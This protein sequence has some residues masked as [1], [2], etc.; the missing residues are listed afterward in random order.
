LY[1]LHQSGIIQAADLASEGGAH[2]PHLTYESHFLAEFLL[3][4]SPADRGAIGSYC[5][6]EY[7]RGTLSARQTNMMSKDHAKICLAAGAKM[8]ESRVEL[9]IE[10]MGHI[11][12]PDRTGGVRVCRRYRFFRQP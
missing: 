10:Q 11:V 6:E 1:D 2:W 5:A 7:S 4:R 12:R 3:E 9:R 8:S